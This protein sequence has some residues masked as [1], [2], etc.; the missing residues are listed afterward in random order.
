MNKVD[1]RLLKARLSIAGIIDW[2]YKGY[3]THQYIVGSNPT[4]DFE[5]ATP[6]SIAYYENGK[7][8]FIFPETDGLEVF[9]LG[10]KEI[11]RWDGSSWVTETSLYVPN[12]IP[13]TFLHTL[14]EEEIQAKTFD[15]IFD[16]ARAYQYLA[17]FLN[18]VLQKKEYPNP[19]FLISISN[20]K[21][22]IS[23]SELFGF[24]DM[25][26]RAG[27]IITLQLLAKS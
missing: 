6:N 22:T 11:L 3:E 1:R 4:G 25:D 20:Q 13:Y 17:L 24:Y 12:I 9:H 23:W 15:I 27:D 7:W 26:I 8:N 21:A 5:G 19:D 18:G 16:T 2:P 14:T 10:T